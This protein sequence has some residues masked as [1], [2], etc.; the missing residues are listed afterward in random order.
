[1]LV[2]VGC[3]SAPP[4]EARYSWEFYSAP[5]VSRE[6]FPAQSVAIL[7]TVSIESRFQVANSYFK[8]EKLA[9]SIEC[10][11][12]LAVD[13]PNEELGR[14]SLFMLGEAYYQKRDY[15]RAASNLEGLPSNNIERLCIGMKRETEW[16]RELY[17]GTKK[18]ASA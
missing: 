4:P 8:G 14:K 5:K 9:Q 3:A 13:Y 16:E 15:T 1:M 6:T 11:R 18:P 10:F 12:V 2:C 7:P 17:F